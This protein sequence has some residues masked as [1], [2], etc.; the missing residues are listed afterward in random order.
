M[1]F[2]TDGNYTDWLR[3]PDD[4]PLLATALVG[5]AQYIVSWNTRD[6]PSKGSFAH[7]R[8]LIPPQFLEEV[9]ALHPA[10]ISTNDL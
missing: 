5:K 7:I 3:D 10:H 9:E 4:V 2:L 8:Y 1:G 6:F